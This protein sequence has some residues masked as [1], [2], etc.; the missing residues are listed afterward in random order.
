VLKKGI[1]SK[2]YNILDGLLQ[3][4]LKSITRYENFT[5]H[6]IKLKA[7]VIPTSVLFD[8]LSHRSFPSKMVIR[9]LW[10]FKSLKEENKYCKKRSN[11]CFT[12]TLELPEI[13]VDITK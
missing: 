1:N 5:V 10:Q 4:S 7:I 8:Y 6:Y 9:K 13:T 12:Y 3:T 2:V 11:Y